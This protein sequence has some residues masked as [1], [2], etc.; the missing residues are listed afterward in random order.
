MKLLTPEQAEAHAAATRRGAL[1]GGLAASAAAA[2]GFSYLYRHSPYYRQLPLGLKGLGTLLVVIPA[3]SIQAERRGLAYERSQ[4]E[5]TGFDVIKE[6]LTEEEQKW[7]QMSSTEKLGNWF[8]RHKYSVVVGSWAASIA[9]AGAIISRDKYQSTSQ[10]VVQARMWA[11]GL[12]IGVILAAGAISHAR[13]GDDPK[14]P[15]DH[16]WKNV[17]EQQEKETQ[18]LKERVQA[19]KANGAVDVPV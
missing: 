9:V 5:G 4:W 2:V 10:K 6:E 16:S 11:Q 8:D 3:I 18:R 7:A 12:T 14:H 1:E 13:H 19:A 15:P 17:V